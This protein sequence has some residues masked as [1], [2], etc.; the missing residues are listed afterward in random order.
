MLSMSKL[1]AYAAEADMSE[2]I[3]NIN[4]ELHLI[5]HQ[6]Q[7]DND[8]LIGVGFDTDNMRVMQP[9]EMIQ[10]YISDEYTT[11]TEVEFR[12]AL[13]L[14]PFV[15]DS[16]EYRNKIWSSAIRRNNWLDV[17]MDVP[18]DKV[19]E[20]YFFK[21]V[22][23][24]YLLDGDVSNSLPPVDTFLTSPDLEELLSE[25]TFQYLLKLAYEHISESFK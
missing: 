15:D 23:L 5:E 25:K 16:L 19:S 22:E 7:I 6:S 8:I 3:S 13:E 4:T 11:A 1:S 10:L 18:L 2:Q 24:C 12:K 20:T 9:E 17:N 14:L 21:L